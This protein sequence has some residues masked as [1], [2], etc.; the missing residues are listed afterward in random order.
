MCVLMGVFCVGTRECVYVT[1]CVC[2][3]V[4]GHTYAHAYGRA[5]MGEGAG[6]GGGRKEDG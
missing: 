2:L 5:R 1:G 4:S 6:R 3:R